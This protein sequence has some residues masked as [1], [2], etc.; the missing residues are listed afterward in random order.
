[1]I[2]D[3]DKVPALMARIEPAPIE[4]LPA[5][6]LPSPSL[7]IFFPAEMVVAPLEVSVLPATMSI[8]V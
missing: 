7:M 6:R 5:F 8:L 1:M 3:A 4:I 2:D